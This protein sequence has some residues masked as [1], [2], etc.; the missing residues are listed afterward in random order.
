MLTGLSIRDVV[1]IEKLDLS[2]GPGL[3]ALTGETGAGKSILL[4]SLGLALGARAEAGLV[5][6][7]STQATVAAHFVTEPGHAER[8]R[9]EGDDIEVRDAL[10]GTD[11]AP[12]ASTVVVPDDGD[13]PR[14]GGFG[15]R[16]FSLGAAP[17]PDAI[18]V[19]TPG[20]EDDV[21]GFS[22][23]D[24]VFHRLF[25][26]GTIVGQRGAGRALNC[27]VRFDSE[28]APRLIAARHL[29]PAS[30]AGDPA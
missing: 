23:G 11:D 1:L 15:A 20:D 28:R 8:A 5:R 19:D 13:G 16:R 30:P 7:G 4:D 3:T 14:V 26:D 12:P 24:R 9:T 6:A 18:T 21:P 29:K 2:F 10:P 27:L 17:R 25:G 22:T